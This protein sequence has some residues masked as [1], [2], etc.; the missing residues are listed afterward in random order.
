MRFFGRFRSS[1][2]VG[3]ALLMLL[4]TAGIA[5]SPGIKTIPLIS[6]KSLLGYYQKA[7]LSAQ[8]KA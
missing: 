1:T 8:G 7:I 4:R 2:Y 6:H 5:G 3:T